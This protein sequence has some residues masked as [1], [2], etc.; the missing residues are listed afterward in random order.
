MMVMAI[1]GHIMRIEEGPSWPKEVTLYSQEG[2]PCVLDDLFLF[3]LFHIDN[4]A[5]LMA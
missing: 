5:R 4:E 2:E 3:V 1:Y